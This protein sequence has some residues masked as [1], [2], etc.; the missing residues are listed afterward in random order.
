MAKEQTTKDDKKEDHQSYWDKIRS[1]DMSRTPFWISVLW[2]LILTI[3]PFVLI[4][5]FLGADFHNSSFNKYDDLGNNHAG[6]LALIM[7]GY[8]IWAWGGQ[9]LTFFLKWQK[10]DSFT[11]TLT[12]SIIFFALVMNGCWLIEIDP[13]KMSNSVKIVVRFLICLFSAIPAMLIGV[14]IT[15]FA[16]N[17]TYKTEDEDEAIL[18]AYRSGE[19]IPTKEQ[20]RI[21]R[22]EQ[23][24]IKREKE[25][26]EL[27]E[28]KADLDRR[29]LT[30]FDKSK[31]VLK[32]E[33][34][35]LKKK[36][37]LDAKEMKQ[38]LKYE[39]KMKKKNPEKDS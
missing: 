1:F 9:T 14:L 31:K 5:V 36:E 23:T 30:D 38:R 29:L 4:W 19:A 26:A 37:K 6:W 17:Y 34:K 7:V 39:E 18:Q 12:F 15:N 33:N 25:L 21:Q 10:A 20:F 16:R 27:E 8:L 24:R 28:F 3:I 22:A 35:D 2:Q 32:K 13:T 11:F